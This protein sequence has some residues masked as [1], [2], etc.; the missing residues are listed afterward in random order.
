[1]LRFVPETTKDI[2]AAWTILKNACGDAARVLQ[3]QTFRQNVEYR[4]SVRKACFQEF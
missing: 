1:M 3:H 4:D 2:D